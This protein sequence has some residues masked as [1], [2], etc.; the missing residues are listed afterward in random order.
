MIRSKAIKGFV[1]VAFAM[2]TFAVGCNN[3]Y[4]LGGDYQL[5]GQQMK[6]INKQLLDGVTEDATRGDATSALFSSSLT[7]A[8]DSI[9]AFNQTEG[10]FG[11]QKDT[12]FGTRRS[13]FFSQY[14]PAYTLDESGFGEGEVTLDSVYLY[15]AVASYAG[16]T[17]ST[18]KYAIYEILD[19]SFLR[20]SADSIF[21]INSAAEI[22]AVNGVLSAEPLLTFNYPDL[23]DNVAAVSSSSM[24]TLAIDDERITPTGS[25]LFTKLALQDEES[26]VDYTIYGDDYTDF[27]GEFKGFY[28]IPVD[29]SPTGTG[30]TYGV[31]LSSSGF[32][33]KFTNAVTST[34]DDGVEATV[35]YSVSMTYIYRDSY[36]LTDIG[37]SSIATVERGSDWVGENVVDGASVTEMLVEGMGGVIS[38][39][40]I[41]PALFE[42]F[43]AWL[44][45]VEDA[46]GVAGNFNSLFINSARLRVYAADGSDLD[47]LPARLG[48]YRKYTNLLDDDGYSAI[49]FVNDYDYSYEATYGTVSSYGGLLNRS[50]GCY[51]IYLP[52]EL[53]EMYANYE[54]LKAEYGGSAADID[55][56]DVTWNKLYLAPI[57]SSMLEPRYATLQNSS[58]KPI[59][60]NITYTVMKK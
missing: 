51:E 14:T 42:Q 1:A 60:F 28:I 35:D 57:A 39:L 59:E 52:L 23:D 34:D 20:E 48:M 45:E 43:D 8:A 21:L 5:D 9:N 22:F 30:G 38:E 54:E 27:I 12:K 44:A 24:I 7:T 16:D 2:A 47:A 25:A 4:S 56:S 15:F 46:T 55:W 17:T 53:Q 41:E 32:G 29:D 13:G 3:D 49:S 36:Y 10:Y 58:A 50:W 37:G 26:G 31:T 18:Q 11:L 6:I 40:T 33:L 19:D